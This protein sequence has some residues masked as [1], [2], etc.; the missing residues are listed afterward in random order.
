MEQEEESY[1]SQE[2][3]D[4][5]VLER[6]RIADKFNDSRNFIQKKLG[7][8]EITEKEVAETEAVSMDERINQMLEQGEVKDRTQALEKIQLLD[9]NGDLMEHF[10]ERKQQLLTE[11]KMTAE[12]INELVKEDFTLRLVASHDTEGL[13]KNFLVKEGIL[14]LE[15]AEYIIK[16]KNNPS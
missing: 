10:S 13:W 2:Q 5:N 8:N 9:W 3:L 11:G 7:K 6:Q 14:D 16:Q 12:E 4:A 1:S 15:T